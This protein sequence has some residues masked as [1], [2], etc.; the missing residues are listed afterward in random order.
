[1][2]LPDFLEHQPFGE[3]RLTGH[4]ICLEHVIAFYREGYTPEQL[5]EEYPTLSPELIQQVIDFYLQNRSEVD[6]YVDECERECERQRQN[7]R[8]GPSLD[9]MKRRLRERSQPRPT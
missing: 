2:N 1:M 6:A 5:H 7:A 3:I 8:K 9:E 4:R